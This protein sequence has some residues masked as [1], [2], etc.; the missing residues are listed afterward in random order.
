MA[1]ITGIV[2]IVGLSLAGSDGPYFPYI[3]FAGAALFCLVPVLARRVK[4][5]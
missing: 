2:F 5:D 4:H 1:H 3:N